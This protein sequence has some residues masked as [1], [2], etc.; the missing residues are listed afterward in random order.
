MTDVC[1]PLNNV[2]ETP[3]KTLMVTFIEKKRQNFNTQTIFQTFVLSLKLYSNN[4]ESNTKVD[5][6]LKFVK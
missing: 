2:K 6:T 4:F 3:G 5:Y 1:S